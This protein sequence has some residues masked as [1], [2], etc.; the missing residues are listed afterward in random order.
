MAS[1]LISKLIL[2]R[3]ALYPE[4]AELLDDT[5]RRACCFTKVKSAGGRDFCYHDVIYPDNH[6]EDCENGDDHLET[7]QCCEANSGGNKSKAYSCQLLMI[8]TNAQCDGDIN[9]CQEQL[10]QTILTLRKQVKEKETTEQDGGA[11]DSSDNTADE[12]S[13]WLF[14]KKDIAW[15]AVSG[16]IGILL[17]VFFICACLTRCFKKP[18][19]KPK[20]QEKIADEASASDSSRSDKIPV[21]TKR[22]KIMTKVVNNSNDQKSALASDLDEG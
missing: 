14:Q 8:E 17:I 5:A 10:E 9:E 7:F 11:A 6:F 13:W 20:E 19:C 21:K 1:V 2:R 18:L 16:G 4:C 15:V 3:L 22:G 12:D